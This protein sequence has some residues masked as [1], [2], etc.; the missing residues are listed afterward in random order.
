MLLATSLTS[1]FLEA[2][3]GICG[4]PGLFDSASRTLISLAHVSPLRGP[5]RLKTRAACG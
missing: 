5:D 1:A 3:V 2:A 4:R